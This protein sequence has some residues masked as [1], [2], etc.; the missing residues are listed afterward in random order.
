MYKRAHYLNVLGKKGLLGTKVDECPVPWVALDTT[1]LDLWS[2]AQRWT[3][4][5]H[6]SWT[7]IPKHGTFLCHYQ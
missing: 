7:P 4:G 2:V 5:S 1:M 6:I 3:V